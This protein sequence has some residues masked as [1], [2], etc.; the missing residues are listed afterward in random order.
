MQF[1]PNVSFWKFTNTITYYNVQNY[2]CIDYFYL[3][4]IAAIVSDF[5]DTLPG[6]WG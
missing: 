2:V 3:D 4:F 1:I 5:N 6:T